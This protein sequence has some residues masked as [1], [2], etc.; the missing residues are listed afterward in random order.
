MGF[1]SSKN[2]YMI[3]SKRIVGNSKGVT[4]TS[5][6]DCVRSVLIRSFTGQYFPGFGLYL[7]VSL[8]IQSECGKIRTKKTPNTDTF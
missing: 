5:Y 1:V 8:R 3:D 4:D 2:D 7:S 6:L